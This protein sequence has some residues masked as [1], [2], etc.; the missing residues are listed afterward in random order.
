MY[1][2]ANELSKQTR[3]KKL[4]VYLLLNVMYVILMFDHHFLM[5]QLKIGIV[6]SNLPQRRL[7]KHRYEYQK[8]LINYPYTTM[9]F[10]KL[11]NHIEKYGSNYW[12]NSAAK[13]AFKKVSMDFL[14]NLAQDLR[15]SGP[16]TKKQ[17]Y[18]NNWWIAVNWDPTLMIMLTWTKWLYIWIRKF[19]GELAVLYRTISHDKDYGWWSNNWYRINHTSSYQT[20]VDHCQ[21]LL[22]R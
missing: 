8:L 10:Q 5:I 18:F 12:H 13:A 19:S 7:L 22:T 15:Y 2:N 1:S 11:I 4:K 17:L 21:N 6:Q 14:K 20:F 3:H 16:L 9:S